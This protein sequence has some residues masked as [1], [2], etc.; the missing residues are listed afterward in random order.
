MAPPNQ[1][2]ET[3]NQYCKS[4]DKVFHHE[5]DCINPNGALAHNS[6]ALAQEEAG[7]D[8]SEVFIVIA[9]VLVCGALL[10]GILSL[11]LRRKRK[12]FI[13]ELARSRGTPAHAPVQSPGL[14]GEISTWWESGSERRARTRDVEMGRFKRGLSRVR[15]IAKPNQDVHISPSAP[16]STT[17]PIDEALLSRV[18]PR[19]RRVPG[20]ELPRSLYSLNRTTPIAD[21]FMSSTERG[22]FDVPVVRTPP[23]TYQQRTQD[24]FYV[25]DD[26]PAPPRYSVG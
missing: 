6:T 25:E 26:V 23:P 11:I 24:G 15:S 3:G 21:H 4:W 22:G 7:G 16:V 2:P 5:K 1:E 13:A 12:R 10:F 17:H 8:G 20:V 19:T 18:R 9:V 14:W